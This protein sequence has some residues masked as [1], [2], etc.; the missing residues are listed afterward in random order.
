MTEQ[1]K[2][3]I[4]CFFLIL[5]LSPGCS[6]GQTVS[7]SNSLFDETKNVEVSNTSSD[8]VEGKYI[9]QAVLIDGKLVA[10][11]DNKD[12]ADL[13]DLNWVNVNSDGTFSIQNG[14]FV[15][16]GEW[17]RIEIENYDNTYLFSRTSIGKGSE[18]SH[19]SGSESKKS[20]IG[21]LTNQDT[22]T[23]ILVD[24]DGTE[25]SSVLVY[26]REGKE[27]GYLSESQ[28]SAS[29]TEK[30]SDNSSSSVTSHM[31]S[32]QKNALAKANQYL[33]YTAFSHDG[34]IDQLE[35]EGYSYSDAKWAADN[36]GANWSEQALKKAED[37][38]EYTAFSY[39]GLIEQLEF[40]GFTSGEA[41]Y[42]ADN[43][44]A[45]WNE[46]AV[47]KAREYLEYSSFSRSDL[48]DQLEFEGF[49]Y[50]QAEY[51]VSKA[52]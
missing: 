11:K 44:N 4:I 46:Q 50:S 41:K 24:K 7:E 29:S 3:K 20:Y 12:I 16:M 42:G 10:F 37:Y 2:K 36:C 25:N 34:L 47:K 19:S 13:Y 6:N 14:V 28:G 49:T 15:E 21:Y 38:L 52:Y 31:T 23:F 51:G 1:I 33:A 27:S 43:C 48:I 8:I 22:N 30:P 18:N 32:S 45:D 40:E 9:A 26:V 35:Y 5:L 39:S 17:S